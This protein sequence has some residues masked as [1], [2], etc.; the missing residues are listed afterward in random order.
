M[1]IEAEAIKNIINWLK[2]H[3]KES[4]EGMNFSFSGKDEPYL[5]FAFEWQNNG[6]GEVLFVGYFIEEN[7][8][9]CNDPQFR[10]HIRNGQIEKIIHNHW[11]Y[12]DHPCDSAEDQ[13]Y[14]FEFADLIYKRHLRTRNDGDCDDRPHLAEAFDILCRL[15]QDG[16][17]I[18][19]E[20]VV[21]LEDDNELTWKTAGLLE[22]VKKQ[23]AASA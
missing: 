23:I 4:V 22:A 21:P 14:A 13:E 3:G 19:A 2:R 9:I 8:D 7:G 6:G 15:V 17:P 12:G 1:Q 16:E 20:I 5:D 10:F 11:M 18:P